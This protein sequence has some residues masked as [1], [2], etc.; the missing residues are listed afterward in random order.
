MGSGTTA[1]VAAKL[2]RNYFGC[3]INPEYKHN[4]IDVRVKEVETGVSIDEAR[5]GQLAIPF[6]ERRNK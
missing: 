1:V 3:E 4:H 5:A 2:G 6:N